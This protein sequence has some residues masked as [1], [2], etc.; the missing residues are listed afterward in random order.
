[1]L[2]NFSKASGRKKRIC[3]KSF[4]VRNLGLSFRFWVPNGLEQNLEV[5][6]RALT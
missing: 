1:M 4:S 2:T 6:P 3:I 5:G